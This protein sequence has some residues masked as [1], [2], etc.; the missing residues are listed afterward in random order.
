MTQLEELAQHHKLCSTVPG[1]RPANGMGSG[2]LVA[3][4]TVVFFQLFRVRKSYSSPGTVQ[5]ICSSDHAKESHAELSRCS[6]LGEK[7]GNS[8]NTG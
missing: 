4:A 1:G 5:I 2:E 3:T 7:T 6:G 8:V